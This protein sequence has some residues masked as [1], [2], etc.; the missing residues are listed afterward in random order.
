MYYNSY[1]RNSLRSVVYIQGGMYT[2]ATSMAR[3]F[4]ELGGKIHL[5]SEVQEL[6]VNSKKV[7]GIKVNGE[8]I[9][10]DYVLV[11]ADFPYA[12]KNLIKREK[13]KGKYTDKKI[14]EMVYSSSAFL[15][16]LGLNKK[17]SDDT[18][19]HNIVFADDFE[20]NLSDIF[21]G[22]DPKDPS[23]YIYIPTKEDP[24]LAPEGKEVLY[25]LTPIPELKTRKRK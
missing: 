14:D 22:T 1:D 7:E 19:L 12:M 15:M 11:D 18:R 8:T 9:K 4:K 2:M 6:F 17:V 16:Y 13:D 5:N 23:I 21:Q 3:L 10:A 24:S 20:K 25:I